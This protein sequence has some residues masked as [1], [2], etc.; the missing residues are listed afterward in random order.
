M[1]TQEMIELVTKEFQ[2][3]G[4]LALRPDCSMHLNSENSYGLKVVFAEEPATGQA[5]FF[6]EKI[7]CSAKFTVLGDSDPIVKTNLA[8][9]KAYAFLEVDYQHVGGG[10]NGYSIRFVSEFANGEFGALRLA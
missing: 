10:R 4:F 1:K 9:N 2:S 6:I 3:R 5:A 8:G 7:T